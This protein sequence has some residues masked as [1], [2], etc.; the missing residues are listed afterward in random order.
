VIPRDGH[1]V[2][3]GGRNTS[4]LAPGAV[5]LA[6]G[7]AAA[8]SVL[9]ILDPLLLR[10]LPFAQ[11]EKLV[12]L[13]TVQAGMGDLGVASWPDVDDWAREVHQLSGVAGFNIAIR[14][15]SGSQP[16]ELYGAVVSQNFF[17]V[18]GVAPRYGRGFNGAWASHGLR[19][20]VLSFGLFRRRFGGDPKVLG[21]A[22]LLEGEPYTVVGVMPEEFRQP[23]PA[24]E[25]KTQFWLPLEPDQERGARYLRVVARIAPQAS[26]PAAQAALDA[27]SAE[28][29]R[30]HS[31][32]QGIR[33]E[34]VPLREYIVSSL[35]SR[36]FLLAVLGALSLAIVAVNL[37]FLEL[38]RAVR[39]LRDI[40]I[41]IALGATRRSFV[42]GMLRESL[43]LA[44][45]GSIGGL[46]V[47]H[48][49]TAGLSAL[50][51]AAVGNL[52]RPAVDLRV[53]LAGFVLAF[54]VASC[55]SAVPVLF[56]LG[57]DPVAVLGASSEARIGSGRGR[58]RLYATI[59]AA[60][61]CF[62]LP[63]FVLTLLA[64][65]GYRSLLER[66][67]G[68]R[69]GSLWTCRVSLSRHRYGDGASRLAVLSRLEDEVRQ[70]P[71]AAEAALSFTLP[72]SRLDDSQVE[73]ETERQ[74]RRDESELPDA[75]PRIVSSGYFH[76]LGIPLL[77]GRAFDRSDRPEG[78][79]VAIV[80]QGLAA[81]L[82]PGES[83]IGKRLRTA[84]SS[85]PWALVV[86]VAGDTREEKLDG[87]PTPTVY[88]YLEQAPLP[89]AAVLARSK[90]RPESL[91]AAVSAAV[92]RLDPEITVTH[93]QSLST[94]LDGVTTAPRLQAELLAG[95]TG[96]ATLLTGIGI[97]GVV[98]LA[99]GERRREF[100]IRQA[101]GASRR[102]LV[103]FVIRGVLVPGGGGLLA[104]LG[105]TWF[106][107]RSE[108]DLFSALG[109]NSLAALAAGSV[110][111]LVVVSAACLIPMRDAA[112]V[113]PARVLRDESGG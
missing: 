106:L 76:A 110:L 68:F 55:A 104:G 90:G 86:G 112:A 16:E 94:I 21:R 84:H 53:A 25:E 3:Y 79:R 26:V 60:E 63:A 109:A 93:S 23:E 97:F 18:L 67:P 88:Y 12:Y 111:V 48:V 105:L 40:G 45:V 59:V 54:F 19:E 28:L 98:S 73:L 62:L 10:P 85:R 39:R 30:R 64:A 100:G 6:L 31:A 113:D 78:Q 71:G 107:L 1:V 42:V 80:S 51:P 103:G 15:I 72:F 96:A 41:R 37:A 20:V 44:A 52:L 65:Q 5:V 38:G 92:R 95:L 57:V 33:V 13:K 91:A 82:W 14:S 47:A 61:V 69:A 83:A 74:M 24:W 77:A 29:A 50:L 99:L 56:A 35:R 101:L 81:T 27:L 7:I 36:L 9:A 70:I 32:D 58:R 49:A 89:E 4:R 46:L 17:S 75:H 2:R 43:T 34:V 87:P 66:P 102:H 108:G 11:P 22:I 8:G